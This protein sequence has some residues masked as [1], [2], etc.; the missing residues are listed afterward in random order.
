VKSDEVLIRALAAGDLPPLDAF[1]CSTGTPWENTVEAQIRGPLPQRYLASPP[2]FDGRMLIGAGGEG[3][4]LVIGAH[5]IE[6]TLEPDVGYT[7]VVAITPGTHS[8]VSRKAAAGSGDPISPKRSP[9]ESAPPPGWTLTACPGFKVNF[10]STLIRH[11]LRPN[12]I[13]RQ[14][15][16]RDFEQPATAE[17]ATARPGPPLRLRLPTAAYR[18]DYS[19]AARGGTLE[20]LFRRG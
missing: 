3:N 19:E 1:R 10:D 11:P 17:R 5:H 2:R 13:R 9:A 15:Q 4:D 6:P 14:Q 20:R 12:P 16:S 8:C 7:E 18:V